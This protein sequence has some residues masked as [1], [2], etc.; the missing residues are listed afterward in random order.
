MSL[1]FPLVNITNLAIGITRSSLLHEV[2]KRS[3]LSTIRL[4]SQA[5]AAPQRGL[6]GMLASALLGDALLIFGRQHRA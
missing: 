1:N 3:S 4:P 5:G 2:R 6:D